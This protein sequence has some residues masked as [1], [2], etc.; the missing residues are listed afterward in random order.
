[1]WFVPTR[2]RPQRLQKFLDGCVDTNMT[3]Q[4]LIVV[5][6]ADGGDYSEVALPNNWRLEVAP[7]RKDVGGRLDR[8]LAD[9]PDLPF[10]SIINDDIVP[11]TPEWDT[12]LAAEVGDWNVVYPND[13]LQG[14]KMATQFIIGRKL[15]HAVGS[16]SLG[17]RHGKMDRAW[18]EIGEALGRLV[19]RDDVRLRHE[20]FSNG[21]AE[22]DETYS[23]QY[24]GINTVKLDNFH[25]KAWEQDRPAL[26]QR[27]KEIVPCA[28]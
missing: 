9:Y 24:N 5:D 12:I 21:L 27:L 26:I 11:E 10:Y 3:M 2:G 19:Y 8:L 18:M 25:W 17:F 16:L 14:V 1:M 28:S 4:G 13:C 15:A 23:R 20:H 7:D 6:G 22:R